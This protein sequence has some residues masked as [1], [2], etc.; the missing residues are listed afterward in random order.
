MENGTYLSFVF[1]VLIINAYTYL[2]TSYLQHIDG[3]I[4]RWMRY[5]EYHST[6]STQQMRWTIMPTKFDSLILQPQGS[7]AVK[8]ADGNY[9]LYPAWADI[10]VV[11]IPLCVNDNIWLLVQM[12][13]VTAETLLFCSSR[14]SIKPEEL[15]SI[16]KRWSQIMPAFMECFSYLERSG[17]INTP[18]PTIKYAKDIPQGK[19]EDSGVFLCMFIHKLVTGKTINIEEGVDYDRAAMEYRRLMARDFYSYRFSETMPTTLP[20]RRYVVFDEL[21]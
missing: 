15:K 21:D 18:A 10:D 4:R 20:F 14:R 9:A 19:A 7:D 11:F 3:W 6:R 2:I 17:R 12:N 8:Y 1:S 13:L 16:L 5:R